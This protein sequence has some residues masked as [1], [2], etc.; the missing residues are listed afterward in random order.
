MRLNPAPGVQGCFPVVFTSFLLKKTVG[1]LPC[2]SQ[3]EPFIGLQG[4]DV[5]TSKLL[6]T[7]PS[8]STALQRIV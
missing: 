7:G 4:G 5:S 8:A 3:W 6:C 2:S 1:D